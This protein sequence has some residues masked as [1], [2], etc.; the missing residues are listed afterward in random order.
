MNMKLTRLSRHL[1]GGLLA[2]V[3]GAGATA[4]LA[5]QKF[6]RGQASG[7]GKEATLAKAKVAAWKNYL[8]GLQGAQLDNIVAN[9]KVFL[10]GIDTYVV[11][12]S[13]VDEKC[14]GGFSSS[15]SISIK[16]AINESLVESRL[17]QL[18]QGG[19]GGAPKSA[20][21]DDIAF[22]VVARMADSQTSFDTK[23]TRRAESTV[24]TSGSSASA[25]AA[26]N[27]RSGSAESSADAVSVTQTSKTVT[28]G[29]QE[30]K[31]DRINYVAWPNI[32]DLQNRVGETLTNNRIATIAWEDLVANCGV[33]D[34]DP[35]SRL[36][37]ESE[38]GQLPANVRNDTFK[39]LKDCQLSKVILASLEVDG[40]RQDPNTGLWLASG[41]MN[42]TVYDLS[43][44]FARSVGSANRNFSGRAEKIGDASRAALANA[45][46]LAADVVVNQL[47]LR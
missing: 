42:L 14:S 2:M 47:N 18:G 21:Q 34:N 15:C 41:N 27:N 4:A 19:A 32:D 36:Y 29:S 43:G 20:A 30:V 28:G 12:V 39:K 40:Y 11:D 38:N 3:L 37:A 33:G 7:S 17:R 24:G 13:V 1:L 25:D 23:V 44:R 8:G 45:A 10:D 46:K 26:A 16:A 5:Q 35:F 6:V 22:L 9:E 31:R